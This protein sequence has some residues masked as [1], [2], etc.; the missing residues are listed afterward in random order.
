[1]RA[2][3][4]RGVLPYLQGDK[5]CFFCVARLSALPNGEGRYARAAPLAADT[6]APLPM[7]DATEGGGAY[8]PDGQI[9]TLGG[10]FPPSTYP[11]KSILP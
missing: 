4:M 10:Y 1:M 6:R 2:R 11:Q 7:C 3:K 8:L 5:A 9:A